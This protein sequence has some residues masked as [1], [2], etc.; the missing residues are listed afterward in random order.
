MISPT[1][2]YRCRV[3]LDIEAE[4]SFA[5]VLSATTSLVFLYH[6]AEIKWIMRCEL[7]FHRTVF[8]R[9]AV[10]SI[11]TIMP[12]SSGISV[13]AWKFFVTGISL[14]Y[15][16]CLRYSVTLRVTVFLH[17]CWGDD[18]VLVRILWLVKISEMTSYILFAFRSLC[19]SLSSPRACF[20]LREKLRTKTF[21][22]SYFFLLPLEQQ[23]LVVVFG[24]CISFLVGIVRKIK[25]REQSER[26]SITAVLTES[27]LQR[28]EMLREQCLIDTFY[29]KSIVPAGTE[30]WWYSTPIRRF[31]H[32]IGTSR[33]FFVNGLCGKIRHHTFTATL[34]CMSDSFRAAISRAVRNPDV[35]AWDQMIHEQA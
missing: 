22:T 30:A 15:F 1:R 10:S 18:S 9:G 7:L 3:P 6:R 21:E 20:I 23:L 2:A 5:P 33:A 24:R 26:E 13:W 12:S 11:V 32:P 17:F 35:I 4:L 8:D 28:V 16:E 19:T 25:Q 27:Y 29:F 31:P 34:E 14:P